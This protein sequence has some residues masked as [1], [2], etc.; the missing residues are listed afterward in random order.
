MLLNKPL[1]GGKVR[2]PIG[3][4][5]TDAL[6][7]KTNAGGKGEPSPLVGF[8]TEVAD[9]EVCYLFPA[10]ALARNPGGGEVV[11]CRRKMKEER[12]STV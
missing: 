3:T 7:R 5:E 9:G 6:Q 8:R 12:M 1:E 11:S 2:M 4:Y 10:L